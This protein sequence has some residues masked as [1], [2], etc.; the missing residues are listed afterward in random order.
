LHE[1]PEREPQQ[2]QTVNGSR[3]ERQP[4]MNALKQVASWVKEQLPS[5]WPKGTVA[6]REKSGKPAFLKGVVHTINR[7]G[8]WI[9][10]GEPSMRCLLGATYIHYCEHCQ[11]SIPGYVTFNRPANQRH[12]CPFCGPGF[13]LRELRKGEKVLLHYRFREDGSGAMWYGERIDW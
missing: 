5:R 1:S 4:Q 3:E 2:L 11:K 6:V 12:H 9:E 8:I 7:N 10:V 13:L